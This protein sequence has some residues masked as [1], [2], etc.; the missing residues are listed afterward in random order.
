MDFTV[1]LLIFILIVI[2]YLFYVYFIAS[3]SKVVS[4][5][6][7]TTDNTIPQIT[8]QPTITNFS[9]D[10]WIYMNSWN[11][12]AS[13]NIVTFSNS[14]NTPFLTVDLGATAPSLTTS[15]TFSGGN[16][17]VSTIT[18]TNNFPIQKWVYV[19]VSISSNIV[20]CYLDGKLVTSYQMTGSTVPV[21][22]SS[23]TNIVVGNNIDA[24][25]YNLNRYTTPMDTNTA[26]RNYY[27]GAPSAT[28]TSNYNVSFQVTKGGA[29]IASA[30]LF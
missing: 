9:I 1:I 22:N 27:Y 14:N 6:N 28:N 20:D 25:L 2:I 26:Q 23:G 10:F 5:L 3:T 30:S 18:L 24:Y 12:N 7:L 11:N 21:Q 29:P 19:I 16:P 17:P 15:I 4:A 13:K 8:T